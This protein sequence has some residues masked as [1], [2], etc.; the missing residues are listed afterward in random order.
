MK[1]LV[2]VQSMPTRR[3]QLSRPL[4]RSACVTCGS[5]VNWSGII[6]V[7]ASERPAMGRGPVCVCI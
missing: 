5:D 3:L 7:S 2:A 1:R 6:C 4:R